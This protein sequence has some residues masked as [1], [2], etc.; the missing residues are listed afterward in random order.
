VTVLRLVFD[1]PI[2]KPEA[3]PQGRAFLL[4]EEPKEKTLK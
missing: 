1:N 4:C 3:I 2:S